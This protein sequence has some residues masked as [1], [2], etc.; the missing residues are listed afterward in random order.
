MN[1]EE[2][3]SAE[4]NSIRHLNMFTRNDQILNPSDF[5]TNIE[6]NSGQCMS[7]PINCLQS[8]TVGCGRHS[9]Q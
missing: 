7:V 4:E 5:P 8:E 2:V 3:S 9:Y 6:F 1:I